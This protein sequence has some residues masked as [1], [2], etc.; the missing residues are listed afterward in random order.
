[1]QNHF[2]VYLHDTPSK[3]AFLSDDRA[4]SHGCI[5]VQGIRSLALQVLALSPEEMDEKIASRE[6]ERRTLKT[7]IPVFIQ[8]WTAVPAADDKTGFRDDV[9]GRDARMIAAMQKLE[10]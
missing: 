1:M 8:Y 4:L 7:P 5:R 2:D 6:T 10:S 9:Y 3:K